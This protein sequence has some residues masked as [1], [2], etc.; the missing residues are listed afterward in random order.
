MKNIAITL[1]ASVTSLIFCAEIN[2]ADQ[3]VTYTDPAKVDA[4]YAIQGEYSGIIG[5]KK[6]GVQVI[7]LGDGKFDAV[8]FA[9]GLPGEGGEN[10]KKIKSSGETKG[11]KTT[12]ANFMGGATIHEGAF[13]ITGKEGKLARTVRKSKTLGMK[14]PEGAVVLFDGSSTD[15]FKNGKMTEDKLLQTGTTGKQLFGSHKIHMEFRTPYKPFARGQGRGNAGIYVQSRY[16]TQILDSF[17]LEGKMNETGGIYSIKAPDFNMCFPPLTWQTYDIDFTAAE[18]KDGKKVKNGTMTVALNGVVVQD[19][20]ELTHRTTA[21]PLEEGP[22]GGPV[23]LQNHG[24]PVVYQ[25]IW[26]LEK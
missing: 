9:G 4:D 7:A 3:N 13:T 19:N 14:A 1:A 5:G 11:V 25:N 18:F 16:E 20:V 26:V 10:S 12:F 6:M 8:G 2:A 22:E 15:A 17:G 24:N 21:S 23:Y